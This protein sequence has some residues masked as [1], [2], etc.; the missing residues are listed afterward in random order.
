MALP[1]F[2]NNKLVPNSCEPIFSN[3]CEIDFGIPILTEYCYKVEKNIAH[4]Y[5]NDHDGNFPIMDYVQ[6]DESLG[7]VEFKYHNKVN[8]VISITVVENFRFVRILDLLDYDWSVSDCKKIQVEF[9]YDKATFFDKAQYKAY[10]RKLKI[11][12]LESIKD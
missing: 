10:L 11:L 5:L 9:V 12:E 6:S 8:E 2:T 4:F 1:H 3:L 7:V